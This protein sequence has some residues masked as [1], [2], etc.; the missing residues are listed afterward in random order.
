MLAGR[1]C[2][3]PTWAAALR[4][5][6]QHPRADALFDDSVHLA[7]R[8][9]DA[10]AL[11]L[12]L[13]NYGGDVLEERADTA[14]ARVLLEE[15]LALRR[16]LGEPRGVATTL[17]NLGTLTL[18]DGDADRAARLFAE[19]LTLAQQAGLV[20]HTAWALTGLRLVAVYQHDEERAAG[21]LRQGLRL[22]RDLE[23][24]PTVAQ[25]LAGLAAVTADPAAAARLWGAVQRLHDDLVLCSSMWV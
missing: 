16:S 2:R 25:C 5:L 15:S 9:G 22:A 4:Q 7:R 17:S 24:R 14:Q 20:P 11:S 18:L 12:A 6:G 13:N 10:W 3:S 21:L 1:W 8:H 19:H 23:D